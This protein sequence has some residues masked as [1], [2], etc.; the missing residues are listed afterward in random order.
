MK[1]V[2]SL[3]AVSKIFIRRVKKAEACLR[4]QVYI[5]SIVT[6]NPPSQGAQLAT[7]M[8]TRVAQAHE[9]CDIHISS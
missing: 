9:E 8:Y 3:H 1:V 7:G 6:L 2:I 4:L 5:A